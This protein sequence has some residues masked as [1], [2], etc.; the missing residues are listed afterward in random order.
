M[1][2][3]ATEL[4]RSLARAGVGKRHVT[5][6]LGITVII[7]TAAHAVT[8]PYYLPISPAFLLAHTWVIDALAALL[9]LILLAK[10]GEI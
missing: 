9:G 10:S 1:E 7:A 3:V 8:A 2:L 5:F 4:E 6:A